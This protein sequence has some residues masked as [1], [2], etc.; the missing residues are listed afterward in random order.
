MTTPYDTYLKPKQYIGNI[1]FSK[2]CNAQYKKLTG[3][4]CISYGNKHSV[5]KC[6]TSAIKLH[7]PLLQKLLTVQYM[8]LKTWTMT[9]QTSKDSGLKYF[10]ADTSLFALHVL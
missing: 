4:H 5:N 9:L 6:I 7:I 2:Q 3:S 10:T 8:K 1:Y